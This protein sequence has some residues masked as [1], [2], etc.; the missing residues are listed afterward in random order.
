LNAIDVAFLYFELLNSGQSDLDYI[1]T[2]LYSKHIVVMHVPPRFNDEWTAKVEQL[3]A[4]YP[5]S[6]LFKNSM[7]ARTLKISD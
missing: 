7:D 2:A 1:L 3:K 5:D 4:R 6:I